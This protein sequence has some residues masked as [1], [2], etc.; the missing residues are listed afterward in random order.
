MQPYFFPYIGYYQL[1]HAVEKF[2]VLDD[3]DYIKGGWINRNIIPIGGKP[4]WLTLPLV[5]PSPNRQ[6]NQTNIA[7]DNGWRKKMLR[8]IHE[9]YSKKIDATDLLNLIDEIIAKAEGNLAEY[10][11]KTIK[12]ISSLFRIGTE[13]LKASQDFP[14]KNIGGEERVINICQKLNAEIYIN[15]PG[16]KS[17]Y[18]RNKFVDSGIQLVFLDPDIEKINLISGTNSI[19]V[20]IIDLMMRNNLDSIRESLDKYNL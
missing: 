10:I 4:H 9:N 17:I 7:D 8:T 6:I 2:V 15:L 19:Y 1:M 18:N 5:S 14:K 11:T 13:I 20:S 16:V 3:V 12:E